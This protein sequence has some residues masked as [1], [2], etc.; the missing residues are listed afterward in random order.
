MP[1]Q[2]L[3]ADDSARIRKGIKALLA[4][5][6]SSWVVCGEAADGDETLAHALALKP[7]IVLLDLS[8]PKASGLTVALRLME[9]LPSI[10]LVLISEQ[11]PIVLGKIV[12]S[13]HL[14]YWVAKSKLATDLLPCLEAIRSSAPTAAQTQS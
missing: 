14:Q 9:T 11:D 1:I 3:I 6:S 4:F 7:D 8:M 13:V 5:K 2:V 10:E 12:E